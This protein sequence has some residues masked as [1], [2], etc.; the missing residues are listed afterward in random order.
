MSAGVISVRERDCRGCVSRVRS[1][2]FTAARSWATLCSGQPRRARER[3]RTTERQRA[4]IDRRPLKLSAAA[5]RGRLGPSQLVPRWAGRSSC[6]TT[7]DGTLYTR[8]EPRLPPSY[9]A[10]WSKL[11]SVLSVLHVLSHLH[12]PSIWFL[13]ARYIAQTHLTNPMAGDRQRS[14]RFWFL[15]AVL[16]NTL[17]ILFHS[18]T[19]LDKSGA[20]LDF[21]GAGSF[22]SAPFPVVI[23][24]QEILQLPPSR[25]GRSFHSTIQSFFC[26]GSK[27]TLHTKRFSPAGATNPQ[28]TQSHDPY[29]P[30]VSHIS[31]HAAPKNDLAVIQNW[32][33]Q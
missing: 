16:V 24:S 17:P 20:M 5:L 23:H 8:Y 30:Q 22:F 29:L 10:N 25:A 21:V 7:N 9:S 32:N 26:S 33:P 4:D 19:S 3:R 1:E 31:T 2:W 14:L 11:D 18:F 15:L 12:A 27:S 28:T 6:S 13:I